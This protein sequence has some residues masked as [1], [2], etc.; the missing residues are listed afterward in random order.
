MFSGTAFPRIP[1]VSESNSSGAHETARPETKPPAIPFDAL[2]LAADAA[3]ESESLPTDVAR[4]AATIARFE[5]VA[6]RVADADARE[7]LAALVFLGTRRV[8][9]GS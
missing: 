7:F 4:D 5:D 2:I 3:R 1:F 6:P 9:P 8:T